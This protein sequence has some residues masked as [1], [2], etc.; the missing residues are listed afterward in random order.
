VTEG[1]F[2]V[3]YVSIMGL[4]R[5][6]KMTVFWRLYLQFF[7]EFILHM[8]IIAQTHLRF[9]KNKQTSYWNTT[10]GFIFLWIEPLAT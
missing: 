2:A 5:C 3:L 7:T 4:T 8:C 6:Y 9:C 10:S 1:I